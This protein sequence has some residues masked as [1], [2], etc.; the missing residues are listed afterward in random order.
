MRKKQPERKE[1]A[2]FSSLNFHYQNLR[3]FIACQSMCVC[4]CVSL[5]ALQL[6]RAVL[7]VQWEAA[8]VHGAERRHRHPAA[9]RQHHLSIDLHLDLQ[10][11]PLAQRPLTLMTWTLSHLEHS[12]LNLE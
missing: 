9:T 12:D 8:E 6:Q 1:P 4:V 3:K 11:W 7:C 2:V 5:T 10:Q